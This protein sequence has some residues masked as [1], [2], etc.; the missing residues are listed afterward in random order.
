MEFSSIEPFLKY[1][2]RIRGRTKQIIALVPEDRLEWSY[3]EGKFTIGD[4][5]RHI[6]AI[7]R[8]MFA[9]TAVG[10]P[11][12]Y[13]GCGIA[14]ASGLADTVAFMDRLH[15]ESLALFAALSPELLAGRCVTP[16]GSSIRVW[17]WL[18]A[19]TEHEIHHRGQ[20]YLYLNLL[21]IDTPALYGLTAEE[22]EEKSV[23][24]SEL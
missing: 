18:R 1:Y 14:L 6:A 3:R 8:Y 19:M 22:V 11:S 20:L 17:K 7:E 21:G 16:A 13:A 23:G 24:K 4:L 2:G 12:A 10:R 15:A 5:I 9:E